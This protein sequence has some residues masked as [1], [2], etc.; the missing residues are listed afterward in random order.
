MRA[1]S[2]RC[3]HAWVLDA[4]SAAALLI[5]L[6]VPG[7]LVAQDTTRTESGV[8]VGITYTPGTR[9]SLAVLGASGTDSVRAM[10]ERDLDWSDRFEMA[11]RSTA[12]G[13]ADARTLN[14]L[15]VSYGVL[16]TPGPGG[17][18]DVSVLESRTGSELFRRTLDGAARTALHRAADD[19]VRAITGQG[20]VAA[21]SLL[22]VLNGRI[23][24]IDADGQGFALLRTAGWPSLSPAWSPDGRSIAYTAFVRSGQ[25]LVVQDLASGARRMVPGTED[26]LN[27]TPAF[28]P[29]GRTLAYAHGTEAGTD[30]YLYRLGAATASD[31]E[32]PERLTAGQFSDNLS[33][34]WSGDGS[35]IA[36]VSSRA[37]TPQLYV[38]EADGTGQE[39]LGRFDYGATGTTSAPA[40]SPDGQLIAFHRDVGGVPQLF[41]LD[42]ATRALRQLTGSGRNEDPT[43]APDSRHLAFVSSR[44]GARELWVMDLETGRLRKLTGV[45]GARLP[46]WSPRFTSIEGR[47]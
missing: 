18:S 23:A 33:P 5:A 36:F 40:W 20:G 2:S 10:I 11:P 42:V 26:G 17:R 41:V 34:A 39:V 6:A 15:G 43:W 9:P 24:R 27:I 45:G 16:V 22:F 12:A 46:A 44:G 25:P 14:A 29:D 47:P 30:I 37:R 38:M 21:T 35:R 31:G 19:I 1:S 13:A 8:R 4:T 28:S 32:R 3:A 7:P